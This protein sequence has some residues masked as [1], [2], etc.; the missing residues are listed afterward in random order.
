[1]M[2]VWFQLV[3]SPERLP[4]FLRA[5][6]GLTAAV[7]ADGTDVLVRGTAHGAI[8]DQY[9]TFLHFDA[10]EVIR[11]A[12]REVMTSS[13]DVYAMAN[14]L[15]PAL[16][17]LREALPMP[18]MSI[19]QVGCSVATMVG[20]RFGLVV[21][22]R[23][24]GPAYQRLVRSYGLGDRLAGVQPLGFDDIADQNAL[25]T[26]ETVATQTLE[27]VHTAGAELVVRGA[28]VIMVPG[29]VGCM[30]Q[31]RGVREVAGAPLLDLYSVL[32]K[33]CE[34][35]G[36]LFAQG[37]LAT[38]RVNRYQQPSLTLLDEAARI[39]GV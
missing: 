31:L 12:H 15:D 32:V 23:R 33:V 21:P 6:Q 4:A 34:A 19:M 3:S 8:A 20:D 17:A 1:M 26:D 9:A 18:V 7:A 16:D 27:R 10:D 37:L 35:V 24:L 36:Q 28:E 13:V 2:K 30:L 11:L 39:Y 14:S 29:P 5:L 25:F 38:S 22:N